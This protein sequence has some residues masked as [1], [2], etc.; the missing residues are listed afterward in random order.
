MGGPAGSVV[1]SGKRLALGTSVSVFLHQRLLG[2]S[3]IL[4][5][6]VDFGASWPFLPDGRKHRHVTTV[7]HVLPRL[8]WT[9]W[10]VYSPSSKA[11]LLLLRHVLF[12]IRTN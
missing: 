4:N 3:G 12:K 8:W 10:S 5:V 7:V 9:L 1:P 6:C 2:Q 11:G